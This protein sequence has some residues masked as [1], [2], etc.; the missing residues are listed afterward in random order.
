VV[1]AL[2]LKPH[3]AEEFRI[4]GLRFLGEQ[5]GPFERILKGKLANEFCYEPGIRRAYLVRVDFGDSRVTSVVL[6]LLAVG[7]EERSLVQRVGAIFAAVFNAKEHLDVV[8]LSAQHESQLVKVCP[9]F[10][11]RD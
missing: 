2:T 11:E 9:P 10:F 5:D 3:D 7:I 4:E 8:F 6:A 1:I